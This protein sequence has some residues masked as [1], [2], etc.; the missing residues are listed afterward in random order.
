MV[1]YLGNRSLGAVGTYFADPLA[2]YADGLRCPL[3]RRPALFSQ[4]ALVFGN[5]Q[6]RSS[7]FRTI[8]EIDLLFLARRPRIFF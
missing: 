4:D 8:G 1:P 3:L 2:E 6:D 5:I 7:E